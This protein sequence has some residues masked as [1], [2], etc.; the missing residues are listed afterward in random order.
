M[1]VRSLGGATALASLASLAVVGVA[2]AAAPAPLS[3]SGKGQLHEIV[4]IAK[5]GVLPSN[6]SCAKA[7][8]DLGKISYA[9]GQLN[10]RITKGQAAE[11]AATAAGDTAKASAIAGKLAKGAQLEADLSKVSNL[12]ASACPGSSAT[13]SGAQAAITH[14]QDR[15][16]E[17]AKVVAIA[18]ADALPSSFRCSNAAAEQAKISSFTTKLDA[19]IARGQAAE[20]AAT[21]AG[22]TARAQHLS[23]RLAK[24]TTLKGD[25]ATV[26]SLITARCSS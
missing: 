3:H 22:N 13:S 4:S 2:G 23:A 21:A 7:D 15:K 9:E 19:R 20:S 10:V 6:F 8:A 14:L 24:A 1:K 26:S 25:L 18:K 16:A 12:I 17:I 11:A 5:S